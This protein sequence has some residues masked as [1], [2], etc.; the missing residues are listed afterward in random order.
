MIPTP[1]AV[2]VTFL[3]IPSVR[4]IGTRVVISHRSANRGDSLNEPSFD[5]SVRRCCQCQCTAN[6]FISERVDWRERQVSLWRI[7]AVSPAAAAAVSHHMSACCGL[8][9]TNPA[10]FKERSGGT[11]ALEKVN[12]LHPLDRA[13][14]V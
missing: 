7:S 10:L 1:P 11:V 6:A 8:R 14:A 4:N 12:L 5:R 3:T 2:L 9:S 13:A